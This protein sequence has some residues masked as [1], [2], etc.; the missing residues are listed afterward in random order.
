ML[1][2]RLL[3][4]I[5]DAFP[6]VVGLDKDLSYIKNRVEREGY[7][8]LSKALPQF[9]DHILTCVSSGNISPIPGFKRARRS[10]SLPALL[11]GLNKMIFDAESG[12]LLPPTCSQA[13]AFR[14]LRQICYMFKKTLVEAN[15]PQLDLQAKEK[16]FACER[17]IATVEKLS[18]SLHR[19]IALVSSYMLRA[20]RDIS[21][22]ELIGRGR[23]GPGSIVE[24]VHG[25]GKWSRLAA[26]VR[27]GHGLFPEDTIDLL[28]VDSEELPTEHTND[29]PSTSGRLITVPKNS[30]SRRTITVEPLQQQFYQQSLNRA[31]RWAI[32]RCPLLRYSL[33]LNDQSVN[34]NL[35]LTA[36]RDGTRATID[37]SSASDLLSLDL[38]KTVFR[39]HPDFVECCLRTRA[40]VC[41]KD[42]LK[43]AGMGNATTFPIQSVVFFVLATI[44]TLRSRNL[45]FC[46]ESVFACA[47]TVSVFG[48]DI[49]IETGAVHA[50][51]EI[52]L[53][54]GLVMNVKKSFYEGPFRESC[55]IDAFNG[56]NV[57]P[58]YVRQDLTKPQRTDAE[59]ETMVSL[60]NQL[61][62]A[63]YPK[64]RD[65]I[66]SY[67]RKPI[68]GGSAY[69]GVC[70]RWLDNSKVRWNSKLHR[71][72]QLVHV[73]QP[74]QRDDPL[75]GEA[76]LLKYFMTPL[77]ERNARHLEKSPRRYS[78]KLRLRWMP[79]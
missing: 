9:H 14:Y 62:E 56:T 17:D 70:W 66:R 48:D 72:E 57:T 3:V 16:F 15:E 24:G 39:H 41:D 50:F 55:G 44:A 40:P 52:L 69:G 68:M 58:V 42:L 32:S 23:H 75:T 36:S 19:H 78:N 31:L 25:N 12:K 26:I 35:A 79:Y 29:A 5:R 64:T 45:N 49:I 37:L 67:V 59:I 63:G 61:H 77:I 65:L 73:S 11:Q 6:C 18:G 4:D 51:R 10:G 8:F 53:E 54:V 2:T 21:H 1:L 74:I 71:R 30:T 60:S 46:K 38:F 34:A 76:A 27:S 33:P 47:R 20:L 13:A 43:Y 7:G 28:F 22:E